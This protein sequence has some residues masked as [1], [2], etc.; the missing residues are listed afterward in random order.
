MALKHLFDTVNE[1]DEAL[2][3]CLVVKAATPD[4]LGRFINAAQAGSQD[5]NV[6]FDLEKNVYFTSKSSSETKQ[7]LSYLSDYGSSARVQGDFTMS[8]FKKKV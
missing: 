8:E 1:D 4:T 7:M 2:P 5:Q 6:G 3:A